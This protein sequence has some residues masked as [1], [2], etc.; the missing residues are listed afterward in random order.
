MAKSLHQTRLESRIYERTDE[1][2]V[3]VDVEASQDVDNVRVRVQVEGF[4]DDT[5]EEVSD[6]FDMRANRVYTE[7]FTIELPSKMDR[8]D[9]RVTIFVTARD[10][11]PVIQEFTIE[12]DTARHTLSI[13]D[14][15]FHPQGAVKAGSS[16]I[17]TVEVENRGQKTEDVEVSISLPDLGVG[18]EDEIDD[19][20]ADEDKTSEE[21]WVRIDK[22]VEPGMYD[23]VVK[24]ESD[25]AEDSITMQVEVVDGGLCAPAKKTV[26]TIGSAVNQVKAGERAIFPVTLA[27]EGGVTEAYSLVVEG[28]SEWGTAL[29]S[30]ESVV[31]VASGDSST[32]FLYIT[33]D[34]DADAEE[35][36]FTM[37]VK[38]GEETL[39]QVTL[40]VDVVESANKALRA[41]EVGLIVLVVILVILG[42][43]IGFTRMRAGKEDDESE[44]GQTY[45]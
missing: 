22:C 39:K 16:L 40:T 12:V 30:P 28:V 27:N 43:V 42:L 13:T 24:A 21:L 17:A 45:Y 4:E 33:P 18:D 20:E 23:V 29:V 44:E 5:L 19:L 6:L 9:Y 32:V 8:D 38:S 11:T 3:S 1:L 36:A 15:D 7:D 10:E 34:K 35:H 37:T 31:Q 25:H 14:I 26:L 2:E 41:L